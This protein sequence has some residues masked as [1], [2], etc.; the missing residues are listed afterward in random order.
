MTCGL[1]ERRG[2]PS[3]VHPFFSIQSRQTSRQTIDRVLSPQPETAL[4][5][6][7]LL[8]DTRRSRRMNSERVRS[9]TKSFVANATKFLCKRSSNIYQMVELTSFSSTSSSLALISIFALNSPQ[10]NF[11]AKPLIYSAFLSDR[12]A[13]RRNGM[14]HVTT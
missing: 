6:F 8:S 14:L 2:H 7:W 9:P 10:W 4:S 3:K 12:P 5:Q 1:T 11:S 13:V